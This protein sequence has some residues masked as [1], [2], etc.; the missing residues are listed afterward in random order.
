MKHVFAI[1]DVRHDIWLVREGT[2]YRLLGDQVA[3][4]VGCRPG[5]MG[6][7]RLTIDG[8]EVDVVV[9]SDGDDVYVHI[10]GQTHVARFIE[11]VARHRR[12]DGAATEDTAFAPMPGVVVNVTAS[13]GQK[14][15]RGDTL[16]VIESMK[17]ETAVKAWRAGTIAAVHVVTGQTFNRGV[18]LVALVPEGDA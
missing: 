2:G 11:P 6:L 15:G 5:T 13:P 16:V 17:L 18:P 4:W 3:C 12:H 7:Q 10:D 9:A 14:V 8:R 1:G